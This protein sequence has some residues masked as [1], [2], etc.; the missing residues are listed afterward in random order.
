[1]RIL[2][3]QLQHGLLSFRF[4]KGLFLFFL[5]I[6]LYTSGKAQWTINSSNVNNNFTITRNSISHFKIDTGGQVWVGSPITNTLF[7]LSVDGMV[8]AREIYVNNDAWPDYVFGKNYKLLSLNELERYIDQNKH[9][10][11][12][13]SADEVAQNGVSVGGTQQ[14]LLEKIEELTLYI[15]AQQKEIEALKAEQQRLNERISK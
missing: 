2:N 11:N 6:L 10:P 9:L 4:Q 14:K 3:P 7:R 15:I 12:I 1:M 13:P 5:L 8:R